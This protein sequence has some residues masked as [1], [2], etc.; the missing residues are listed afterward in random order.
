MSNDNLEFTFDDF[1][2]VSL[3]F[4]LKKDK[5]GKLKKDIEITTNL[6]LKPEYILDKN[7]LRLLMKIDICGD[8]LPFTLNIEGG[9]IFS[10]PKGLEDPE[11]MDKIAR[12]NCAAIA[13]PYIREIVADVVRRAGLPQ[14][15]LPPVNFVKFYETAEKS[16]VSH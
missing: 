2:L 4:S 7:K 15:N 5:L 3:N 8:E 11:S 6:S 16:K 1:R 13:Y 14:L 10:F 12:I 9:S